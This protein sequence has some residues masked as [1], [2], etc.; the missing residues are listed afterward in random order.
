MELVELENSKNSYDIQNNLRTQVLS[1]RKTFLEKGIMCILAELEN[2]KNTYDTQNDLR[3]QVLSG[4]KT[5]LEKGI[6]CILAELEWRAKYVIK[7]IGQRGFK[8]CFGNRS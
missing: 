7:G 4:R 3:T 8:A 1:G 2:S 6:M 5:F